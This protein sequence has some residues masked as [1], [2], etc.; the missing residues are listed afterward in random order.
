MA[1]GFNIDRLLWKGTNLTSDLLPR[2]TEQPGYGAYLVEQS[3]SEELDRFN[4]GQF[5]EK[6]GVKQD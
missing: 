5:A 1:G 2:A 6:K 4:P 3:V